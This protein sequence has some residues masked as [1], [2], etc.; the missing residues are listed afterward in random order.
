MTARP[1]R[2]ERSELHLSERREANPGGTV[3]PSVEGCRLGYVRRQAGSHRWNHALLR[4]HYAK[5]SGLDCGSETDVQ[6][7]SP[8]LP[9]GL[10]QGSL[11]RGVLCA[12]QVRGG[13]AFFRM[14]RLRHDSRHFARFWP[15]AALELELEWRCRDA[16]LRAFGAGALLLI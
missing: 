14:P 4:E 12:G 10:C 3:R 11:S 13:L 6:A 15:R 8:R 9:Q 7:Q 16:D 2:G 1:S 5:G